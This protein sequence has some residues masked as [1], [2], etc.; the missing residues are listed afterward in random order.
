MFF[1]D[2]QEFKTKNHMV[3][4]FPNTP[5]R[6]SR[7]N[8][9]HPRDTPTTTVLYPLPRDSRHPRHWADLHW[10]QATPFSAMKSIIKYK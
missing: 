8:E 1:L 3:A 2:F 9:F 10:K 6:V 7:S 5:P 4:R